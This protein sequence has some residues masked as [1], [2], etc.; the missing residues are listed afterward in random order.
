M[1][2]IDHIDILFLTNNKEFGKI[3]H[4]KNKKE[5]NKY[6]SIIRKRK[7]EWHRRVKG[8]KL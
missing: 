7:K 1:I 8:I 4:P 2:D 6:I 3:L 5:Y